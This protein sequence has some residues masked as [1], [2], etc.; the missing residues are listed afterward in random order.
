MDFGVNYIY[1]NFNII[2]VLE[3]DTCNSIFIGI[4]IPDNKVCLIV[5]REV[6][7]SVCGSYFKVYEIDGIK[8]ENEKEPK[9]V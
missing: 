6:I 4:R 3:N 1:R 2:K 8:F 5:E 7:G 9:Q